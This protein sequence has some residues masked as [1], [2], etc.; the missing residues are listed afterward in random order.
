MNTQALKDKLI[1]EFPRLANCGGFELLHCKPYSKMITVIKCPW[2]VKHLKE[3]GV[4]LSLSNTAANLLRLTI[5]R[6]F[7][8]DDIIEMS[9]LSPEDS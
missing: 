9:I 7:A 6:T 3:S 5:H 4:I 1:E 2:T 8:M